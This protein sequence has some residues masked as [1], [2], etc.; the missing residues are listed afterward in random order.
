MTDLPIPRVA[1]IGRTNVGKSTL[2]NRLLERPKAL[3]SDVAGTT[4]DRNEGDCLWRGNV[5]RIIDTGGLD[6]EAESEIERQTILQAKIAMKQAD[7]ILFVLDA[8][9][10]PLPQEQELARMLKKSQV[11]VIVVAN[12]AETPSERAHVE[13]HEWYL[14][15][16]PKP[17]AISALRGSGVGDLLDL[18][19][20]KLIARGKPPIPSTLS[21]AI[22]VAVIGK[23]NV[24]KSTLLNALVG[25]ER[26]ITSPTAHTTREPNDTLIVRDGQSYLFIDTAGMRKS[27]KV[28]KAGGLEAQAV[29][30]NQQVVRTADVTL[31]VID[32]SEPIGTQEKTLAG[33]IKDSGSGVILVVNKWDLVPQKTTTTMNRFREYV[34]ASIPFLQIAPV[35]FVSALTKQR[36]KTVFDMIK[37]VQANR[38]RWIDEKELEAFLRSALKSHAPA[39]GKGPSA[40]KVLGIKQTDVAPLTFDLIVK[41]KRE[42]TLSESYI[43]FLINRLLETF[44]LEGTPIRIHIRTARS[45]SS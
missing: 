44:D 41:A 32:A 11:P 34:A 16:L 21:D 8:K 31:F 4:R 10:G 28:R 30:R 20:E 3:V 7:V 17:I 40:P 6:V 12:K 42:S 38:T 35:L 39:A 25:E 5:I 18:V 27:G 24:G 36:M 43:R 45:V 33:F 1:L 29:K 22:R 2:F 26:F 9:I 13:N 23:P 37:T 14:Q 15:G 19:Y